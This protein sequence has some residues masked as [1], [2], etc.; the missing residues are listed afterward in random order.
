MKNT[1]QKYISFKQFPNPGKKTKTW[2]V[3][4]TASFQDPVGVIKWHGPWRK[5]VFFPS[6]FC[7]FDSNCLDL[8]SEF[9]KKE[10]GIKRKEIY[11]K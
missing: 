4:S 11:G 9:L 2:G 8:I 5:Y 1:A 6:E 3:Y 10:N 7:L